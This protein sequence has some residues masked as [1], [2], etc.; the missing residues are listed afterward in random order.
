MECSFQ[1]N[2]TKKIKISVNIDAYKYFIKA[3]FLFEYQGKYYI[4]LTV[5]NTNSSK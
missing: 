1:N 2:W 4:A 3:K 5:S